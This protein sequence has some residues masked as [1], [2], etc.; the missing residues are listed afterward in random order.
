MCHISS[1]IVWDIE[2]RSYERRTRN[3][4]LSIMAAD[5]TLALDPVTI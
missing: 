5:R 3:T 1:V 4:M 2:S